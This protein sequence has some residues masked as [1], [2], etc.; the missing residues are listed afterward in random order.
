MECNYCLLA[1]GILPSNKVYEDDDAIVVTDLDK[2]CPLHMRV[3]PKEHI[4]VTN[5][6][7]AAL[8]SALGKSILFATEFGHPGAEVYIEQGDHFCIH[9]KPTAVN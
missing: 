5:D 8:Y 1:Q 6:G 9:I 3:F 7:Y 4:N 2:D